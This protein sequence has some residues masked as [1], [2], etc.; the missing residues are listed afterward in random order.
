MRQNLKHRGTEITEK[1]SLE[2]DSVFSVPLCFKSSRSDSQY[3]RLC[4]F[5]S[6]CEMN[7]TVSIR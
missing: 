2:F 5:A 1:R 7:R 4:A 6:L 3:A